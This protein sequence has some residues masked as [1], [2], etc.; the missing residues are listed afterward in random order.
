MNKIEKLVIVS[1]SG[2]ESVKEELV[3]ALH[4]L[5]L[6]SIKRYYFGEMDFQDLVQE[7]RLRILLEIER[8]QDDRGV[9]FLGYIKLQM[10]YLYMELR[11]SK[12]EVLTLNMTTEEGIEL[13]DM[14]QG[15]ENIEGSLV[16][17]E[18]SREL[19]LAI[20]KLSEGQ[21]KVIEMIY[22]KGMTM[23]KVSELL[24]LHYQ[25]V[26]GLKKRGMGNLR[27]QLDLKNYSDT[28]CRVPSTEYR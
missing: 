22:I 21:K 8:F 17:F 27:R 18:T 6:V 20:N 10:K 25:S 5:I 3:K 14:L 1:R 26:I 24:G 15:D 12:K 7:G 28:Q 9:P 19:K 4:P 23:K 11:R 13:V 2:D 16:D